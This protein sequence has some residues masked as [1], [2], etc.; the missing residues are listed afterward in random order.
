MPEEGEDEDETEEDEDEHEVKEKATTT[1][2]TTLCSSVR[3]LHLSYPIF[4]T[5]CRVSLFM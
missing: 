2:T 5:N 3:L 1:K 4:P